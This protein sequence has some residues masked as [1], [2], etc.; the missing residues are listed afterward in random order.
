MII[1]DIHEDGK[2]LFPGTGSSTETGRG[3][4]VGTKFNAPLEP[5]A[6]D[7]EFARAFD[8]IFEFVEKLEPEFIFFQCGA[9]SLSG[10]PITRLEYSEKAHA[11]AAK[12]LH[13][14]AHSACDGR[15]LAIGGGGYEMH[16]VNRAWAGV[17]NELSKN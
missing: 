15:I 6:G 11:Y 16:N 8:E 12:R 10:D 3:E 5:G 9:D 2:Y 7:K 4:A 1:G 13:D 14:L 17:V